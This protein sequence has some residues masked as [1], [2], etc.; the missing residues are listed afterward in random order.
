MKRNVVGLMAVVMALTPLAAHASKYE[1]SFE[2]DLKV[3][4]PVELMV[5]SP[6]GNIKISRGSDGNVHIHAKIDGSSD[7]WG[8][9]DIAAEIREIEQNPPIRQEGN[10]ITIGRDAHRTEHVGINYEIIVPQD[11][12]VSANA[13]AG[14]VDARDI[15]E[16]DLITGAGS[17]HAERIAGPVHVQTGAGSIH[18]SHIEGEVRAHTGT[19]SIDVN[20]VK[21]DVTANTGVG[22][23]ITSRVTGHVNAHTGIG[24]VSTDRGVVNM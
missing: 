5:K 18:V 6:A 22:D 9:R 7:W 15:K 1:G 11:T 10:R 21:G 20:D 19:G 4:G 13:G 3:T 2:R 16:A 24:R 14:T 12:R 17:V 8:G 23:V